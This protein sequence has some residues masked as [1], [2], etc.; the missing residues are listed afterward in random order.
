MDKNWIIREDTGN[1]PQKPHGIRT[2]HTFYQQ[3]NTSI[4]SIRSI[5]EA[6]LNAWPARQQ[7]VDDG[8][9]IRFNDGYTRRANSINP[10]YAA[11]SDDTFLSA[12][13]EK[14]E[15]FYQQRGR[16]TIFKI[17]PL[18]QPPH[19]DALL[20]KR[21]YAC[22]APTGVRIRPLAEPLELSAPLLDGDAVIEAALSE[23][24]LQSYTAFSATPPETLRPMRAILENIAPACCYVTQWAKGA[25]VA[26]GLGVLEGEL[27]GLYDI[28]TSPSERGKGY[29]VH[30]LHSLLAW[31]QEQGASYAYLAVMDDNAPARRLY[32][33]W[34]FVEVYKY[35]YRVKKFE[36]QR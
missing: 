18:V 27:F 6:S 34:G 26:S 14:W 12:R 33:K 16:S 25:P 21:G 9:L 8:W 29:G 5:E 24:W 35:W 22:E 4:P 3:M 11:A 36:E 2:I 13:L 1:Y 32:D 17:T 28:V 15:R 7:L 19:L 20:A 23:S 31:A 10:L 30:L